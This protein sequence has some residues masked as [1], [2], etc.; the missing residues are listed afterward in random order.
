MD[1]STK[2][3]FTNPITQVVYPN[4][5]L[6][7]CDP[8][9]EGILIFYVSDHSAARNPESLTVFSHSDFANNLPSLCTARLFNYENFR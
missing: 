2:T 8:I 1:N 4:Y 5:T 3:K 9:A 6:K 7:T